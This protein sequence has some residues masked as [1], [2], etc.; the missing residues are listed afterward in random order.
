M[1]DEKMYEILEM[2]T[3]PDGHLI[4]RVAINE[5]RSVFFSFQETPTQEQI[6]AEV[7]K[8]LQAEEEL[9]K[10]PLNISSIN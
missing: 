1:E 7:Q 2:N 8:L 10:Q 9:K 5:N 6:D 4:V 3:E